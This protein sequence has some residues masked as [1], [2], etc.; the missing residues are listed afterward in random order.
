M[1][2]MGLRCFEFGAEE[3]AAAAHLLVNWIIDVRKAG[4]VVDGGRR[5][6]RRR[7]LF[8]FDLL[9]LDAAKFRDP[10]GLS[11]SIRVLP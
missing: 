1:P 11:K 10:S 7:L 9:R 4:G 6:E 5:R 8:A 3:A 2:L